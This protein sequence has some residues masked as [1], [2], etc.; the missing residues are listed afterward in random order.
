MPSRVVYEIDSDIYVQ[1][2]HISLEQPI[3]VNVMEHGEYRKQ[4]QHRE[5]HHT[6]ANP[7]YKPM[8]VAREVVVELMAV[9]AILHEKAIHKPYHKR[10]KQSQSHQHEQVS[11]AVHAV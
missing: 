2:H 11:N 4:P 6:R 7:L 1:R 10:Q 8:H 9:D 5:H 3:E